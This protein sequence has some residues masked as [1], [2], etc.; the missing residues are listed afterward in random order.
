MCQCVVRRPSHSSVKTCHIQSHSTTFGHIRHLSEG[1]RTSKTLGFPSSKGP[2]TSTFNATTS[3]LYNIK[4]GNRK[5]AV[6]RHGRRASLKTESRILPDPRGFT[7]QIQKVTL[8][9]LY[10]VL[11]VDLCS[12]TASSKGLGTFQRPPSE[13]L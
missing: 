7:R 2:R 1:S 8:L 6:P 4:G 12:T 3:P 5:N 11:W 10:Y 13:A 9:D